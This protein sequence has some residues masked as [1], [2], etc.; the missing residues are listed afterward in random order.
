[1]TRP[2]YM[3]TY[4]WCRMPLQK[5][6]ISLI[7][8]I[9]ICYIIKNYTTLNIYKLYA[10]VY[11]SMRHMSQSIIYGRLNFPKYILNIYKF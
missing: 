1:M 6:Q 10:Y 11:T 2:L 4:F 5:I 3:Y 8:T 7:I 9:H